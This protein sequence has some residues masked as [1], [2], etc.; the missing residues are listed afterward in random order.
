[1]FNFEKQRPVSDAECR[2]ESNGANR[3]SVRGLGLPKMTF[4]CM[5]S[6]LGVML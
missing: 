4:A 2:Q 6:P 1:M 5:T 3:F